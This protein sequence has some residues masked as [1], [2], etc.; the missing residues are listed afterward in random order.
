MFK[1]PVSVFFWREGLQE[2]NVGPC[3]ELRLRA[4]WNPE[5]TQTPIG[6]TGLRVKLTDEAFQKISA[7]YTDGKPV[8]VQF[9][10]PCCY[11]CK[12]IC[13]RCCGDD[14]CNCSC[15]PIIVDPPHVTSIYFGKADVDGGCKGMTACLARAFACADFFNMCRMR[16]V[17]LYPQDISLVPIAGG[18]PAGQSMN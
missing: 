6:N 16:K 2:F 1:Q 5:L 18:G 7:V 11:S 15:T 12:I 8:V 10:P 14:N 17:W 3:A 9:Q 4:F 13:G